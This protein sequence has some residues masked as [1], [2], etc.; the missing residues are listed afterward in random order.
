MDKASIPMEEVMV[1][2]I[3]ADSWAPEA[4]FNKVE[5][6]LRSKEHDFDKTIFCPSQI[7]GRNCYETPTPARTF[8]EL[9]QMATLGISY[10]SKGTLLPMSNY[11]LSYSLLQQIGFYDTNADSIAEDAHTGMKAFFDSDGSAQAIHVPIPFNQLNIKTGDGYWADLR[12]KWTQLKRHCMGIVGVSYVAYRLE[13]KGITLRG[14]RY[15]WI[16]FGMQIQVHYPILMLMP[17]LL[18]IVNSDPAEV[19]AYY[20]HTQ[21]IGAFTALTGILINITASILFMKSKKQALKSYYNI[22]DKQSCKNVLDFNMWSTL[23]TTTVGCMGSIYGQFIILF[24][25]RKYERAD[26]FVAAA[27]VT[28]VTPATAN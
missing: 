14:L 5:Q 18:L 20:W 3:D 12:S 16:V 9:H 10:I 13:Q 23:H 27:P 28:P 22:E 7:N 11:S 21:I 6:L 4:Y 8:D 1:T 25:D 24:N 2:I 17:T 19:F 26:K 15:F